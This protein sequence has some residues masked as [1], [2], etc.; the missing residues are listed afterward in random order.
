MSARP[1]RRLKQGRAY[2]RKPA[3]VEDFA[4]LPFVGD[5]EPANAMPSPAEWLRRAEHQF[6]VIDMAFALLKHGPDGV[7]GIVARIEQ[8]DAIAFHRNA[9]EVGA[10][11]RAVGELLDTAGLRLL[12]GMARHTRATG[13][14]S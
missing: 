5:D 14:A 12:A 9:D 3:T 8:E 6:N 2:S 11:Y 10:Y 4:T 7:Q 1:M 13:E